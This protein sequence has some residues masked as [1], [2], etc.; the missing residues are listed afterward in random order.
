MRVALLTNDLNLRQFAAELIS[1][2]MSSYSGGTVS[3]FLGG[4]DKGWLGSFLGVA[5]AALAEYLAD[6][7]VSSLELG[8]EVLGKALDNFMLNGLPMLVSHNAGEEHQ[9]AGTL[10][11]PVPNFVDSDRESTAAI[12]IRLCWSYSNLVGEEKLRNRFRLFAR[13]SAES[14]SSL[15]SAS[16]IQTAGLFSAV[17]FWQR[18]TIL[19]VKTASAETDTAKVS[20]LYPYELAAPSV[21]GTHL[22]KLLQGK[23]FGVYRIV[24][25]VVVSKINVSVP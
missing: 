11:T 5:D 18:G 4:T 9:T 20:A 1:Q 3:R 7:R 25:G 19:A 16:S 6:G 13:D 17:D 23:P 14:L 2:S 15:L 8:A 22:D 10:L 21:I 24:N 12:A